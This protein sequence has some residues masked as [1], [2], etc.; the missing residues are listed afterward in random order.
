MKKFYLKNVDCPQCAAKIE[1]RLQKLE[2]VKAVKLGFP[3]CVLQIESEDLP[4]AFRLIE[5]LEPSVVIEE[6][7]QDSS[8]S[9]TRIIAVLCGFFAALIAQFWGLE[10]VGYGLLALSYILATK[11]VF[12]GAIASLKNRVF[13]DE[14][15][16]MLSASVAAFFLQA[17]SE[18]VAIMVFYALGEH[19]QAF[20]IYRSKR[21]FSALVNTLPSQICVLQND[22]KVYKDIR[23]VELGQIAVFNAGDMVG[24]DGE[25]VSGEGYINTAAINGESVPLSIGV[26]EEILSGSVVVDTSLSVRIKKTYSDS[27]VAKMQD[28]LEQAIEQ[29]TKAQA[30]IT[31]FAHYYTPIVFVLSA[32]VC[33]LPPMLGYGEFREWLYRGLVV[34]M[35]SCP[36]ALVLAIPLS[37]FSAIGCASKRGILIK[38]AEFL[39]KLNEIGLIAFDKTGTLTEGNLQIKSYYPV[40]V[41]KEELLRVACIAMQESKHVIAQSFPKDEGIK[42]L[43]SK[44]VAGRGV[45]VK[46]QEGSIIAGNAKLM[47]ENGIVS[48]EIEESGI[49]VHVAKDGVYLGCI[50]LGDT[51]KQGTIE[52]IENLKSMGKK[53]VILSG[54][55]E[56]NVKLIADKLQCGYLAQALPQDKYDALQGYK[57]ECGV[58]FVGDGINDAPSLASA[59]IGVSM[60]IKGSDISKQGADILLLKDELQ[61]L[62]DLF[63]IA[64]KTRRILWQ[65][66]ALALGIKLAFVVLGV[67]GLASIWEAVF[68]DVG[69]SLLALL[70]TLRIFKI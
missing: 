10:Y 42:L 21:S 29:K 24:L 62:P 49:V 63:N 7:A 28:L 39:E 38:S 44:E 55:N 4:A 1:S 32:L 17:Y 64:K 45:I 50:L 20:A 69:V 51:L 43:E 15:V 22:K 6:R 12:K 16:L 41:S 19:L 58:M 61:A 68:G 26:G 3:S 37:Y 9:H 11:G 56:R 40:G 34:L 48:K 8:F 52:V 18:A 47:E 53:I 33:V 54:D 2:S 30:F 35:V 46:A 13:F 65:N 5:E 60:G 36:C 67:F 23:E 25:V 66:V 27:F 14:N 57:K 31:K 59:D 70:N